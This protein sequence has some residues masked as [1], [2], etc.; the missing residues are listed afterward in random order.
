ML[1]G[2]LYDQ[3]ERLNDPELD[4]DGIKREVVRAQAM[5]SLAARLVDNAEVAL[6]VQQF[7]NGVLEPDYEVPKMLGTNY[8]KS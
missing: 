2:Y 7:K 5:S 6:K 8:G 4:D 3:L 1:S